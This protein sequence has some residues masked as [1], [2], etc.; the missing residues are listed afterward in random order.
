MEFYFRIF[1]LVATFLCSAIGSVLITYYSRLHQR[2]NKY[3]KGLMI[4]LHILLYF[5][6][7]GLFS[8]N[9]GGF[10]DVFPIY[11][12]TFSRLC[13]P[14]MGF[15]LI[16]ILIFDIYASIR[17][18]S[19]KERLSITLTCMDIF[20]IALGIGLFNYFTTNSSLL[21]M[22]IIITISLIIH[23]YFGFKNEII[24]KALYGPRIN[25]LGTF[26]FFEITI[27]F[28]LLFQQDFHFSVDFNPWLDMLWSLQRPRNKS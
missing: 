26:L 10:L 4:V 18:Y 16:S 24:K 14:T 9:L 8:F 1:T 13:L 21:G 6:L 23:Q 15:A 20:N 28:L 27:T 17:I 3:L 22:L 2:T 19:N 11:L 5:T 25:M 12:W 7:M